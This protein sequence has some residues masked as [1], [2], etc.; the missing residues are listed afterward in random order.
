M[1][2]HSLG[3][4]PHRLS[5]DRT[6]ASCA[7][8]QRTRVHSRG[9]PLCQGAGTAL[10]RLRS[11]TAWSA[12][13]MAPFGRAHVAFVN[14]YDKYALSAFEQGAVDYLMKP[15]SP[16]RI[17]TTVTRLKQR[18]KNAPAN[19]N[20]LL[21]TLAQAAAPKDFLRRVTASNGMELQLITVDE[22]CYFSQNGSE[23]KAVTSRRRSPSRSPSCRRRATP[24]CLCVAP[25]R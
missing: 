24:P 25:R 21:K 9:R 12:T 11:V 22:I 4:A 15:F 18:L 2:R 6:S 10:V 19:L 13:V 14:A 3:G 5:R 17:A 20:G 16:A 8:F 7:T 23:A 1:V